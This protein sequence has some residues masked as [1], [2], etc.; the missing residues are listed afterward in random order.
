MSTCPT[1]GGSGQTLNG[2]DLRRLRLIAFMGVSQRTLAKALGISHTYYQRL[3][4][5]TDKPIPYKYKLAISRL[6][7]RSATQGT[8]FEGLGKRLEEKA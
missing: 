2:T 7:F 4:N 5:R 6:M 1:C 3:E 8:C